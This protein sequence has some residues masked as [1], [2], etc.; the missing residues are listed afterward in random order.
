MDA[1]R[2]LG[3]GSYLPPKVL[4]NNDLVAMGLDTSDEWITKRTGVRERRV[5]DPGIATSDLGYEASV[6]ALETSGL[7]PQ[8][9]DLILVATITPDTCCPSAANWLVDP[10]G[11]FAPDGVE[12][13]LLLERAR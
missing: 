7:T 4:S 9:I 5:A 8:D 10:E 1:M 2:I 3:T 11:R 12:M 6:R 13:A